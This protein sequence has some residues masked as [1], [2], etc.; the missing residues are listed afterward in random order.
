M[1]DRYVLFGNPVAHSPSPRVH[2]AFAAQTGQDLSYDR[3]LVPLGEFAAAA[4]A[5]FAGGGRGANVTLP[6][7]EDAYRFATRLSARARRAAAVNTLALE[8]DGGVLGDNTDGVGL[9]RDLTLNLGWSIAG[10]RV[11]ILGAG[12]AARGALGPLLEQRPA[13]VRIANRTAEKAVRLAAEF[14]ALGAIAGSGFAEL[15]AEAPFDLVI[16]ATSAG[17]AGETPPLPAGVL[18][19]GNAYDMMYGAAPTPF[20]RRAGQ[21]GAAA[22]A[23]GLGMLVEQAAE[24]FALWRGVRPQTAPVI[25]ALRAALAAP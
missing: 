19:G 5:F 6:F 13:L 25:A 10:R 7:K 23:D 11:L 12:G 8:P 21:Q 18:A 2:A 3:L 16:N 1:T 9:V 24:S 15:R 22:L 4:G 20:L 14:A 17:L